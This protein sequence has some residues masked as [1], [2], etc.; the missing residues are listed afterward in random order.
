MLSAVWGGRLGT[1][2]MRCRTKG[3]EQGVGP[4]FCSLPRRVP[5]GQ[6]ELAREEEDAG[7]ADDKLED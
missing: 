4:G 1:E 6:Y 2:P 5:E 7:V 3:K